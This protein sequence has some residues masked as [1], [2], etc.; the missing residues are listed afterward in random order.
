MKKG[1]ALS[2]VIWAG[3][4][5]L[6]GVLMVFGMYVFLQLWGQSTLRELIFRG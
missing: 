5:V 6:V 1:F 2:D 3:V 4:F